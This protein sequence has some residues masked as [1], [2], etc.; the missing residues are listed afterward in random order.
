MALKFH[1]TIGRCKIYVLPGY[2]KFIHDIIATGNK[3]FMW[4]TGYSTPNENL[5]HTSRAFSS[6]RKSVYMCSISKDYFLS[7]LIAY[8][9]NMAEAN[10]TGIA[11]GSLLK[12]CWVKRY[13]GRRMP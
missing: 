13:S 4:S 5:R 8:N 10:F 7:S 1:I 9:T 6:F 12:L 3:A 2:T 11:F